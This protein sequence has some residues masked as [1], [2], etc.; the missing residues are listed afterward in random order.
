MEPFTQEGLARREKEATKNDKPEEEGEE[1]TNDLKYPLELY[2]YKLSGVLVHSGFAEGGHYYS[3]IKDRENEI[4]KDQWYE[5]N[6][7]LVKE[8]DKEDIESECF[9]GEEK[10]SDMMG[11]SFYIKSSEKH[12]NAYV[13]FY[14]KTSNEDIPYSDS[15]DEAEKNPTEENN[16]SSDINMTSEHEEAVMVKQPKLKRTTTVKIPD[17][18]SET[19]IEENRKYW[20]YRF[21]FSLEYSDFI[22]ELCTLWNSM[23]ITPLNYETKNNDYNILNINE[24][25]YKKKIEDLSKA[26]ALAG[27]YV[28]PSRKLLHCKNIKHLPEK[29]I[30]PSEYINILQKYAPDGNTEHIENFEHEVFKLTLTFYLTVKQRAQDKDMIPEFIDLIKSYINKSTRASEWCIKQF[31]NNEIIAENLL[32]CPV[33]DMRK[34]S[35]GIMYCAML[36]LYENEKD[37]L[38]SYWEYKEGKCDTFQ[39]TYLGNFINLLISNFDNAHNYSEQNS[40]Y[41]QLI[42]RF[43]SLGK[44]ARLYLLKAKIVGRIFNYYLNDSSQFQEFFNDFSDVE[45]EENQLIEIGFPMKSEDMKLTLWEELIQKKRDTQ[46]ADGQQD[47]TFIFEILSNCLTSCVINTDDGDTFKD[48]LRYTGLHPN[49]LELLKLDEKDITGILETCTSKYTHSNK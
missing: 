30:L 45:F 43:S 40:Q 39:K 3:F 38:N 41:F 4:E 31:S 8:F 20:Q 21:M 42:A 49:E 29:K 5:F 14:E 1:T 6:D 23:N 2:N 17:E 19:L 46:I 12:R 9:G 37:V 16:E 32:Q 34:L 10:F 27:V 44:E 11:H 13:L 26:E 28:D 36:K 48:D 33:T 18:I 25:E 35:A 7:E 22:L 15:E 47:Y 24:E